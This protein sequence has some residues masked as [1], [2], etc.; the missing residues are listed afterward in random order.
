MDYVTEINNNGY[1]W[2]I[3]YNIE[4]VGLVASPN[5][6]KYANQLQYMVEN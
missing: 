6:K 5:L 2:A 4:Y 3:T 1:S